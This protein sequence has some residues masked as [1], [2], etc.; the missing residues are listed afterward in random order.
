MADPARDTVRVYRQLLREARPYW[1]HILLLSFGN[2]LVTPLAL[3]TPV[4]LKI[5]V[6]SMAGS[7]PLPPLFAR[8]FPTC[9]PGP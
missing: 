2:L 9:S 7:A 3:V 1:P 6:D 5:A 4:P 8:S